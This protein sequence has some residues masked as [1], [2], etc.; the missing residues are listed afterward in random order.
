MYQPG[1]ARWHGQL[2]I[3]VHVPHSGKIWQGGGLVYFVSVCLSTVHLCVCYTLL[4]ML[5]I[6]TEL[7]RTWT[8]ILTSH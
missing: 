7:P 5:K 2:D 4:H 6:H 8:V 1:V 3:H